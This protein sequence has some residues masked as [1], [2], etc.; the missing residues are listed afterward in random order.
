MVFRND[1]ARLRTDHAPADSFT[2]KHMA[3]NLV[4]LAPGKASLRQKRVGASWNDD[5]LTSLITR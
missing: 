1:E 3:H 4:R 5:F 2:L